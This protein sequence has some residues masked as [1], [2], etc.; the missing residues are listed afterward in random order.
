[1]SDIFYS[2][3]DENLQRELDARAATGK[4][5][6]STNALNFMLG[7]IANVSH[8]T[9]SRVEKIEATASPEIKEKVSTGQIS[10]NEAYQLYLL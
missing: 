3:L 4:I 7:K 1:M 8:D 5:N 6:R 2:Q 9:I 10:I